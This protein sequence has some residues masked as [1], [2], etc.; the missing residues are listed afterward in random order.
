MSGHHHHDHSA[1][2]KKPVSFTVP[3]F[4]AL[5]FIIA[6]LLFLSLCDP[7]PHHH[8]AGEGH[9]HEHAG[10]E[11]VHTGAHHGVVG[12]IESVISEEDTKDAEG[13]EPA[14]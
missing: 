6:M 5:A 7:K 13:T 10:S 8:A 9:G 11:A 2:E 4:M 3:F 1:T 14:H 12:A